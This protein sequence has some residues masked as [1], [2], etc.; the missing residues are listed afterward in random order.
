MNQPGFFLGLL[1]NTG[2]N[3]TGDEPVLNLD[4]L[5]GNYIKGCGISYH[6]AYFFVHFNPVTWGHSP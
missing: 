4:L 2:I 5:S 6:I 1:S 3:L